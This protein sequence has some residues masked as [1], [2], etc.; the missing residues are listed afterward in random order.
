MD[1]GTGL[2]SGT[3]RRDASVNSPYSVTTTVSNGTNLAGANFL[4]TVINPVPVLT[5]PFL[6]VDTAIEGRSC[7]V[8]TR[9][10][11]IQTLIL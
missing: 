10:R 11:L 7:S 3:L 1:E 8:T 5:L 9:K 6:P 4:W 2:I